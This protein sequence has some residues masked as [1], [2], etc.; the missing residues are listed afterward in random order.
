MT[1]EY[2][3][4]GFRH[5]TVAAFPAPG[6]ASGAQTIVKLVSSPLQS[7]SPAT[8]QDPEAVPMTGASDG[9][10]ALFPAAFGRPAS[11]T[12]TNRARVS[13][14]K[15]S[16]PGL[17]DRSRR[18]SAGPIGQALDPGLVD[19][20]LDST[21]GSLLGTEGRVAHVK[22]S[23]ERFATW[24]ILLWEVDA[25]RE[26][27]RLRGHRS[28]MIGLAFAPD[29]WILASR[30][31]RDRAIVLWG[32]ATGRP[33]RRQTVPSAPLLFLAFSPD[34]PWLASTGDPGRPAR[35]W[36]LATGA[37]LRRLGGI[38]DRLTGVS[39]SPDGRTL[40]ATGTDADIRMWVLADLSGAEN[41]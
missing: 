2:P 1:G 35:L 11:R 40:V 33:R 36:D 14:A 32:L 15:I 10:M 25:G 28:P 21:G 26:R 34:G 19:S 6:A 17:P 18:I 16:G 29:G 9:L 37:V 20:L 31:R 41:R 3:A 7:P 12:A 24:A 23:M 27:G 39:F 38:G 4:P 30:G 8:P 22:K 5:V 13:L